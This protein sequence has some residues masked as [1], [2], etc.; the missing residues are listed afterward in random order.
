[1]SAA[2]DG[3]HATSRLL[4]DAAASGDVRGLAP[5]GS[6]LEAWIAMMEACLC[7]RGADC[8]RADAEQAMAELSFQ[9]TF[10]GPAALLAGC[11]MLLQGDTE[12]A[13]PVLAISAELSRSRGITPTGAA[14][15]AERAVV[16]IERGEW[17]AAP[18]SRTRRSPS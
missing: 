11:A 6:S 10:R 1:M 3:A 12:A 8:M 16:A 9:S 15:L 14:A 4:A 2:L 7:R 5:D 17:D 13:D 18:R